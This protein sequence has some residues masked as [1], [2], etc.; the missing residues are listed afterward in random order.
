MSINILK[1]SKKTLTKRGVIWLGQ[2]CNLRCYFCYFADKIADKNHP[3]NKFMSI[4][5]AEKICT[6]LRELY[7]NTAV[8][9]QGGEPLMFPDIIRL[10]S[11]CAKIGLSPSLI[12]NG[13]MLSSEKLT[14]ACKEAGIKDFLISVHSLGDNYDAITGVKGSSK[15]QMQGIENLKKHGIPF[16]FNCTLTVEVLRQLEDIAA[17]A[18]ESGAKVVNFI[19]F[20]PFVDQVSGK[21]TKENVPTYSDIKPRLAQAIDYLEENGIEA[22]VRYMPMCVAE[23]R[24]LKNFYNFQQLSYDQHEWDFNSWTW[25]TRINQKSATEELDPPYPIL[26]FGIDEYNGINFGKTSAH[27]TPE[28]YLRN[29]NIHE[30]LLKLFSADIPKDY[31][32]RQN[33]KLRSTKHVGYKYHESCESCSVKNICDG[34]HSD[35]AEIFGSEEATPIIEE[36]SIDEP[37]FYIKDQ[38]KYID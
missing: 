9:I 4:E 26:L 17:F 28:H 32:Y 37:L 33:A 30:H 25:T 7:G 8:D 21:R 5:K 10:I 18:V 19:A 15:K 20:N 29:I 23:K 16:R 36:T 27:G 34:F 3:E 11:H 14:L 35:Y 24:H 12:S 31:L 1:C 38:E 6:N 13:V 2:T 22:N